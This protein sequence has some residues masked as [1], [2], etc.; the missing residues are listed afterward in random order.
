MAQG[1][2]ITNGD[3]TGSISIY[4]PEFPDE[5]FDI[6]F[7][8]PYLVAMANAGPDTN[9]SQFFIT[10]VVEERLSGGYVIFGEVLE[11]FDVVDAMEKQ[12][13]QSGATKNKVTVKASGEISGEM[14]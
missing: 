10:F 5:N 1:G 14:E 7:E 3:G 12:G 9:G 11:G 2:D 6:S 8:K 4:G 13:S